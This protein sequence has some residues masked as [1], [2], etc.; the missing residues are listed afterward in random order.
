MHFNLDHVRLNTDAPDYIYTLR[1]FIRTGI[2]R[3][4]WHCT[5]HARADL[6]ANVCVV[7]C[8]LHLKHYY[9]LT[10]TNVLLTVRCL[11][12]AHLASP[13]Q[14]RGDSAH[15]CNEQP[16]ST[17]VVLL[18]CDRGLSQGDSY[19]TAG[20]TDLVFPLGKLY[21]SATNL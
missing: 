8:P 16:L 7:V 15:L 18:C 9:R 12:P 5:C 1:T 10:P 6:F 3:S 17:Q 21:Q 11:H 20:L 14:P 4:I 13:R 19:A 2:Y